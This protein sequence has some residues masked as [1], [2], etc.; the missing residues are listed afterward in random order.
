ML[1][2]FEASFSMM[3]QNTDLDEK[4]IICRDFFSFLNNICN[5]GLT[6]ILM[7]P[8]NQSHLPT[9]IEHLKNGAIGTDPVAAKV[10]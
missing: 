9:V 3:V 7:A 2:L 5:C 8:P 6:E 10:D 1:S 4:K